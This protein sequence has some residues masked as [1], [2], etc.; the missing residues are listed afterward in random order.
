LPSTEKGSTV[1]SEGFD[2]AA[3]FVDATKA[4]VRRG[5]VNESKVKTYIALRRSFCKV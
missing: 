4:Y 2:I 3:W 5:D 1:E